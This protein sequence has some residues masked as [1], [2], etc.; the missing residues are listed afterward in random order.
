MALLMLCLA[1]TSDSAAAV[2]PGM[3]KV[4]IYLYFAVQFSLHCV[5]VK[6]GKCDNGVIEKI[7]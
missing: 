1:H 2:V 6:T 4:K 5:I 3:V 7:L